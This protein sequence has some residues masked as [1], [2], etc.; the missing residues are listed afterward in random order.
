MKKPIDTSE[1]RSWSDIH[2]SEVN[3]WLQDRLVLIKYVDY[4]FESF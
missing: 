4:K 1:P 3:E 2:P